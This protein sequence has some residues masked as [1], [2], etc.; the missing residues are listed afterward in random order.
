MPQ[1]PGVLPEPD[2]ALPDALPRLDD[3]GAP[4]E[5][6][7]P[8]DAFV[9]PDPALPDS[10]DQTLD[11][12]YQRLAQAK[13]AAEAHPFEQ[14]ILKRLVATGSATL[15]LMVGWSTTAASAK[16]F[17][18][19][20]DLLDQVLL[21]KPDYAEGYNRRAT[22]YYMQDEYTRAIAD[23]DRALA[24]EPRHFGALSGLAMIMR[25]IDQEARAL[26]IY[27]RLEALHP[28]LPDV[29]KAID[30]LTLAVDGRPI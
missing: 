3:E 17:P 2:S 29:R 22:I 4:A 11:D 15:D 25:E 12:L 21:Q 26:E 23:I 7:L 13:S 18:V 19:S 6:T 27:R 8:P 24:I 16:R 10:G 14:R 5:D 1:P 9:T 28:N 30:E 20:L